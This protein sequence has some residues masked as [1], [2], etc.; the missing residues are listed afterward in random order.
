MQL[1][2]HPEILRDPEMVRPL[3]KDLTSAR[4]RLTSAG[5]PIPVPPPAFLNS[6]PAATSAALRRLV[7]KYDP[8]ARMSST[9]PW[10][11]WRG[12]GVEF[13][14]NR[15]RRAGREDLAGDVRWVSDRDGDHFGYDVRSF[16]IDGQ[17][18]LLE[19]KT[20]NG[21][22]RTRFWLSH[23]QCE[24]AAKNPA[25]YRVRRVYHFRNGTEMFD[26]RPPLDAGLWLTPDKFGGLPK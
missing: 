7:G 6:G 9:A 12:N 5:E 17:A 23:N 14:R 20:T 22:T 13:E 18:R 21:H 3:F 19:V 15:L 26:I 24:V 4:P 2:K 8:A 10:A 16:E 11:R 25:T 1:A